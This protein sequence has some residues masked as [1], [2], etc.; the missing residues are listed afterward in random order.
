MPE[1]IP[2][3]DLIVGRWHVG[4]GRN[5]N[6]GMWDGTHFLTITRKIEDWVVKLEPYYTSETGTFQPFTIIDE[7]V[8]VA[9]FGKVLYWDKHY[10]RRMEFGK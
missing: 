6:V 4:R 5:G 7:G 1:Q 8:M 3:S 9:P 2:L 10:G